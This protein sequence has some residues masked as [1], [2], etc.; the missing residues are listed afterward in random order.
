MF[1][2]YTD[3]RA[4]GS[5][6]LIDPATHFTAGAGMITERGPRSARQRHAAPLS[7]AERLAH[8]ARRAGIRRGG[9]RSRAAG[10]RGDADM[11]RHARRDSAG[12]AR[13]ERSSPST[14]GGDAPCITSS[15]QAECVVLTHLLREGGRTSR[16]SSSTR[17]I[18]SRRPRPIATR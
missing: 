2:R 4:T 13:G 15:F 5:F 17:S 8:M 3:N 7:A 1:D 16:C 11:S 14:R 9:G 12:L 6:I 18:T 10:A